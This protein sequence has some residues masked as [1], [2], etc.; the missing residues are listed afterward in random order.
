MYNVLFLSISATRLNIVPYAPKRERFLKYRFRTNANTVSQTRSKNGPATTEEQKCPT[1]GPQNQQI[2][3]EKILFVLRR[4]TL[5]GP[6][7]FLRFRF[8][9]QI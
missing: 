5:F 8:R 9:L 6:R 1:H 7:S 4:S 3:R 2:M